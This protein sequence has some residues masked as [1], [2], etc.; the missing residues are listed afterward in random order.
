MFALGLLA[1]VEQ[2][3][4]RGLTPC[5]P[6]STLVEYHRIGDDR[7]RHAVGLDDLG[8]AEQACDAG[9]DVGL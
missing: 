4:E 8:H 9:H 5:I 6:T 3:W 7:A 2:S 1:W